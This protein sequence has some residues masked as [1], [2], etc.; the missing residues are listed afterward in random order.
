MSRMLSG[1]RRAL[2][3]AEL[4]GTGRTGASCR[5]R[6]AAPRGGRSA[7]RV[8]DQLAEQ[9]EVL[10]RARLVDRHAD[11]PRVRRRPGTSRRSP[12]RRRSAGTGRRTRGS[13]LSSRPSACCAISVRELGVARA[14]RRGSATCRAGSSWLVKRPCRRS[15]AVTMCSNVDSQCVSNTM[16]VSG[17]S[18]SMHSVRI[19]RSPGTSV[20]SL[21]VVDLEPGLLRQHD[22]GHVRDERGADDLTHRLSSLSSDGGAVQTFFTSA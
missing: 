13:T 5:P 11:P 15:C 20:I 9:Q 19:R 14:C 4:L 3:L 7:D 21:P 2:V 1:A 22:R 18:R 10:R 16:T 8:A 6:R 17:S 12:C